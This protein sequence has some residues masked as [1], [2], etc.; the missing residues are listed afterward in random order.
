MIRI[1]Q[2]VC[3][4]TMLSAERLESLAQYTSRAATISGDWAEV[5]VSRGGSALLLAQFKPETKWLHLFDTFTGLPAPTLE[6]THKKGEFAG[7]LQ[8]VVTLLSPHP[9]VRFYPGQFP[10]ETGGSLIGLRFSLVHLDCDL[11]AGVKAGLELFSARMNPAGIIVLDDYGCPDCPGAKR[12]VDEFCAR[13]GHVVFGHC[14]CQV[15]IQF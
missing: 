5:G 8:S 2:E 10:E 4:N 1:P 15:A 11:Y 9:K 3:D 7:D 6:D 12:A 14:Q 13:T